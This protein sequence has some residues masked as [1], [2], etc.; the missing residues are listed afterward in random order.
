MQFFFLRGEETYHRLESSP[1]APSGTF[2]LRFWEVMGRVNDAT[3][4]IFRTIALNRVPGPPSHD[5]ESPL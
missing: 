5:K 3:F 4:W 2:K 1:P